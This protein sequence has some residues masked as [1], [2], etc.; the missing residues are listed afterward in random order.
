M[1]GAITTFPNVDISTILADAAAIK[2]KT[3]NLPFDEMVYFDDQNGSPGTDYPVGTPLTPS[4]DEA[5]TKLIAIARKLRKISVYGS[6]G[7]FEVPST[8][9]GYEFVGHGMYS[10]G[11]TVDFDSQDVD[12]CVFRFMNIT[13]TQGGTGWVSLYNCEV[14]N[15]IELEALMRD[16]LIQQ[17]TLR[18]GATIDALNCG[19]FQ[20]AATIN[21]GDPNI[22]NLYGWKGDLILAGLTAGTVNIYSLG[23]QISIG[24]T[25]VGGT[26]NIYGTA[27]VIDNSGALCTVTNYTETKAIE[28]HDEHFHN[29]EYWFGKAAPQTE[30]NWGTR[31]SLAPYRA[32]SGLNDFGG[33][34]NDEALVIGSADTPVR[35]NSTQFDFRRL[36]I[37][38]SSSSTVYLF[39]IIHGTGTMNEAEVAGQYTEIPYLKEAAPSRGAPVDLVEEK[40]AVGQKVWIR[41]KN[42]TDN[43]TIDF[44]TG[45]HEYPLVV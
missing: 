6:I 1:A 16:T 14:I 18:S 35:E 4:N 36:Q 22:V 38:A 34:D 5:S 43:A 41:V 21:L 31:A 12:A 9:N 30:T 27:D 39:R 24:G 2:A 7:N 25:C 11:D 29:R 40:I 33:D 37:V 15:V 28:T 44:I 13:G 3:D 19:S 42:A 8:M 45:I 10:A 23:G 20:G 26:I 32:I 17:C